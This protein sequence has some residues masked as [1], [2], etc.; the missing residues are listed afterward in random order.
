M[1]L[2]LLLHIGSAFWFVAGLA[3]RDVTLARARVGTDMGTIGA[4]CETA[5]VFDRFMVTPGSV[6][7]IVFGLVVAFAGHYGFAANGWMTLSLVLYVSV[8]LLVP[9]VYLPKGK[10]FEAALEEAVAAGEPTPAFRA[11]FDDRT[12]WAT[13]WYE[14]IVV[15]VIIVLMITKPF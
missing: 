13:R 15:A 1:R 6:A 4:L 7:V 14:R 10:V 8:G 5:G 11:A 3:G 9:L 12:V 2:W